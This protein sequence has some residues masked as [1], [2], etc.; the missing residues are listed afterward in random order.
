MILKFADD[1]NLQVGF[2][3]HLPG[4]LLVYMRWDSEDP[5]KFKFDEYKEIEFF[6][7]ENAY[8]EETWKDMEDEVNAR[9]TRYGRWAKLQKGD[10]DKIEDALSDS[11]EEVNKQPER[12]KQLFIRGLF[13]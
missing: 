13:E 10:E 9:R 12:I 8:S 3:V 1:A 4:K 5:F 6:T 7:P 2:T 11:K